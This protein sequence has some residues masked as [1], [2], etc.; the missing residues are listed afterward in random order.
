[1]PLLFVYNNNTGKQLFAVGQ[2]IL[3]VHTAWAEKS[4]KS[5]FSWN[6]NKRALCISEESSRFIVAVVGRVP[7]S[8]PF[9]QLVEPAA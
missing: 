3:F 6:T 7:R 8:R 5:G 9:E 2:F 4:L 1:M